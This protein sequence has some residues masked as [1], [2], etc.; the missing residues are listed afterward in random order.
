M[1][2]EGI[3]NMNG[4]VPIS[5]GNTLKGKLIIKHSLILQVKSSGLSYR[6]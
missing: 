3:V 6:M 1:Q 2:D 5:M 4:I